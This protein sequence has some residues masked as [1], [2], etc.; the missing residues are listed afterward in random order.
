MVSKLRIIWKQ[1]VGDENADAGEAGGIMARDGPAAGTRHARAARAATVAARLVAVN[2]CV[3]S[4]ALNHIALLDV[5]NN[6][7]FA[8]GAMELSNAAAPRPIPQRLWKTYA[9]A[10]QAAEAALVSM[11]GGAASKKKRKTVTSRSRH[12]PST[13]E[14]VRVRVQL[15]GHARNNM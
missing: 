15:I 4:F 7:S 10:I 13:V 8:S 3:T 6:I 11:A 2:A 5:L 14:E 1:T 12:P 9:G